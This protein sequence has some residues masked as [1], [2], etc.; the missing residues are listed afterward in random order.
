MVSV[1]LLNIV[2]AIQRISTPQIINAPIM[3]GASVAGVFINVILAFTLHGDHAGHDHG[4][5]HSGHDHESAPSGHSHSNI[6]LS[7]AAIHVIG[8]LISSVGV[9]ISS[10]G[11]LFQ[12]ICKL[13][14]SGP[15]GRLLTQSALLSSLV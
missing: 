5:D 14:G 2:E 10:I 8:D 11:M 9:L 13:F 6:N 7:S 1:L 4:H 3:F 15:L 12:L